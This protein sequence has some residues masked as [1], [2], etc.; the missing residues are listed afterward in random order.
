MRL[1]KLA[2]AATLAGGL[3]ACGQ[4]P[5]STIETS[6]MRFEKNSDDKAKSKDMCACIAGNLDEN[7]EKNSL[8]N[9]AKAFKKA[10]T[11][12]DL[13]KTLKEQGISDAQMMSVMGAAKS[14]KVQYS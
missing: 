14:C 9:V 3:A 4:S 13:E 7:L 11:G 6:C 10:K 5:K 8:K 12:D 2:V 1:L